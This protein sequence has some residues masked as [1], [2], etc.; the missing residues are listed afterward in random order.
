MLVLDFIFCEV[1]T[2]L[3]CCVIYR[4]IQGLSNQITSS[5]LV[6]L[7]KVLILLTIFSKGIQGLSNQSA[8]DICFRLFSNFKENC[9]FCLSQ[10]VINYLMLKFY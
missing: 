2:D 8:F 10:F 9:K 1:F 3:F 4:H 7:K 6:V 5:D